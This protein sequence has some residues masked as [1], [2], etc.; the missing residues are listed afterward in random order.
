[1]KGNRIS[2]RRFLG[3]AA[4]LTAGGVLAG[5][6]S[7]LASAGQIA[8]PV[9]N[10]YALPRVI[11]A[12]EAP[13]GKMVWLSAEAFAGS[14]DP[15]QHMVLSQLHAEWNAFDRLLDF[16]LKTGNFVP[17]LALDYKIIPEG[18]EFTLREGVKFHDG[19]PFTAADVKYTFERA[20]SSDNV[21]GDYF[22]APVEV[23]IVD[24][25]TCKLLTE[26]PLPV[27]NVQSIIAITSHND[28]DDKLAEGHNGTG[29]FKFVKYA[30]EEETVYYEANEDYW[31]GPPRL[32]EF[33]MT[34][35]GDPSTRLAALQ[36][37]E[38]DVIDRVPA[39][40]VATIEE[41]PNLKMAT[42]KSTELTYLNFKLTK[43]EF[44]DNKLIRHAFAHCIDSKGIVE[45]IMSGYAD[46]PTSI[47]TD[48]VWPFGA[49]AG[50]AMPTFDLDAARQELE[51]AGYPNG[52]GLPEFN[53]IGVTGFYPNMKEYMEYI[54]ATCQ[55]VGINMKIEI[56]ETAAWL[57]SYFAG[58]LDAD[59]IF[60][61]WM[62]MSPEPDELF[63]PFFRSGS[64]ITFID[65]PEVDA[66]L[67]KEAK[68][69]DLEERAT[70]IRDE[71]I[72]KIADLA[73]TI[74][75]VETLNMH[76]TVAGVQNYNIL[77]NSCFDLWDT[78]IE[79]EM[80]SE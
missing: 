55:Q 14:W 40:H 5:R 9:L 26:T 19:S 3:R 24:D 20:S 11:G 42:S 63:L 39:D 44:T 8:R 61:G 56:K 50:D 34:Y 47:I 75:I 48:T 60:I 4:A 53:V 33:I 10:P 80:P 29:S 31:M 41:D 67:E 51:E 22:P 71:V 43:S 54:A 66:L 28:S 57:D 49:P 74:P 25:Y 17:K 37:G 65:D 52:E 6:M 45:G 27:L 59:A 12:R 72:P 79:E 38:A 62:N 13:Q 21:T 30:G 78:Y 46:V 58:V 68:T 35:V 1:M 32:K 76:G 69:T 77:G 7:G 18:L 15:T 36:T 2:R 73:I 64:P 70:I 23:E 16:D